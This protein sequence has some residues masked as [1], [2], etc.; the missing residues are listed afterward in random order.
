MNLSTH[1]IGGNFV[2]LVNLFL[3]LRNVLSK[4]GILSLNFLNEL[5]ELFSTIKLNS[6]SC[7]GPFDIDLFIGSVV[8]GRNVVLETC[9]VSGGLLL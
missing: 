2:E 5:F 9:V 4:F 7:R 3:N 8:S 6:I 1:V